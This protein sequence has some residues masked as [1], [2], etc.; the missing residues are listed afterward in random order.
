MSDDFIDGLHTDL[1]EAMGRYQ[2]RGRLAAALPA[3]RPAPLVRLAAPLA[4][5]AAALVAV[6][7]AI[8]GLAPSPG[9]ARPHVVATLEIG[10]TPI[11]AA[12]ADGSLWA[13][14]FTGRIVRIDPVGRRVIAR[15]ELPGAPGP[16]TTGEG[17]VWVQTSGK[18]CE[19]SLLRIDPSRAGSSPAR[20]MPTPTMGR[21]SVR[22][23]S[24]AA[25]SGQGA[26]APSGTKASTASIPPAP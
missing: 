14:D 12:V 11:D 13:T 10:G 17:S 8:V 19:G 21:G 23:R 15:T 20:S 26:A 2:Q 6:V 7:V 22:W 3:P 9:P 1:V 4:A 16:V 25:P 5:V 24:A 18:H